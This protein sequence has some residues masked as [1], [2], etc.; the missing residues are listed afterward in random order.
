M[1]RPIKGD[2]PCIYECLASTFRQTYPAARLTVYFCISS[3]DDPALPVVKQ[4]LADFPAFDA[5]LFVEDEDPNLAGERGILT[6]LGPNPK[7]RNMSRAYR[8]AKGDIMWIVDCNVWVGPSTANRMVDT[9]CGFTMD[10]RIQQ[11]KKY[12]FVH[13]LP[14]SVDLPSPSSKSNIWST[15]GGL[16]EET[17]LSTAHAKFYTAIN[18]VA[19]APCI[20]GKSNMFRRS[21]L[22]A[23][24]SPSSLQN[25][26]STLPSGIDY[27]SSN[28]CEDH[29]I[30][31]LL[32]KSPVPPTI[33]DLASQEGNGGPQSSQSV[34]W[35]KHAMLSPNSPAN[36]AIQPTINY[37]LST[38][39]DRR[40]R[41]LRVRK[42]TV[43]LATL[44][45]PGTESFLCSA[46]AAFAFT[47]LPWFHTALRI[48]QTW[49]ASAIFWLIHI[50]LWSC[51][52]HWVW[53]MLHT[54]RGDSGPPFAKERW[55]MRPWW[56]WE[57]AWLGRE[58]LAFPIWIW[59]IMNASPASRR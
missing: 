7:I 12:M 45:E 27:F 14:L 4:L 49:P 46:Y 40:T 52:D 34:T 18:T 17:F 16:L 28:I 33:T 8:E 36:L 57:L 22:N 58:A 19:V 2:E 29:L 25:S 24:T 6:N 51:V 48:P 21:H 56:R 26:D 50:F 32:W 15:S 59:A 13:Q 39:I 9:L 5:E 11:R 54:N 3:R 30:G 37:S 42:F 55:Q 10:A 41:W 20:V 38:Y 23:L 44:I 43:L 35:G 47:T 53:R 1:I 31:D